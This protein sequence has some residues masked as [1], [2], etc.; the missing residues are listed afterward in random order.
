MDWPAFDRELRTRR[1]EILERFTECLRVDTVSQQPE[2][3]RA[4]AAWLA[5]AMHA[6][7]LEARVLETPGNPVVLGTRMVR[8]ATRTLLIYCHFDTKPAPPAGWP[9]PRRSSRSSAPASP[10]MA[11]RSWRPWRC[12]TT[13]CRR[14]GS[15]RGGRPTTRVH[16]RQHSPNEHLRL[17]HLY[18]GVR[19][20]ARLLVELGE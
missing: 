15:T 20:T 2:R 3:V 6:R 9:S 7:G 13:L 14:T 10:R 8:G 18:Q 4:G 12:A 17:D 11:L 1:R 16:N 5:G 19:T